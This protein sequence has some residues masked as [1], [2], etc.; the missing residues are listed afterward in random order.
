MTKKCKIP[1]VHDFPD[2][3]CPICSPK[4][5][6][7]YKNGNKIDQDIE[8]AEK[9]LKRGDKILNRMKE[10]TQEPMKEKCCYGTDNCPT[11]IG[12]HKFNG[13]ACCEKC[14][15]H[16]G[17]DCEEICV[18]TQ[19][20]MEWEEV[21]KLYFCDYKDI[22]EFTGDAKVIITSLIKQAEERERERIIKEVMESD[23]NFG[24]VDGNDKGGAILIEDII[25][26]V[27][28]K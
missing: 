20:P 25:K 16:L 24:I 19:E 17:I 1:Y 11:C 22:D 26:I 8:S 15:C 7:E 3:P 2:Y 13:W 6:E 21:G 9:L 23:K 5:F 14:Q 18:P 12:K 4:E 10:I 28:G 27:K